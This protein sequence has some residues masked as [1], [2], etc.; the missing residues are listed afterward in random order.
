MRTVE[1]YADKVDN[2]DYLRALG[3]L[4]SYSSYDTVKIYNDGKNDLIAHYFR[5]DKY[6]FTI[7]AIFREGKYE[8]HS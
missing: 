4:S 1:I 2:E 7:G 8:F 6:Q 3:Y 5:G